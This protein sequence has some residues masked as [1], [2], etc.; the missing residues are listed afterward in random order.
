[1]RYGSDSVFS[2]SNYVE[3][4]FYMDD[5]FLILEALAEA[6]EYIKQLTKILNMTRIS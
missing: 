3:R 6:K 4:R 2:F 5:V 1:M